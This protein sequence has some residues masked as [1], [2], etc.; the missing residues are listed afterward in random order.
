MCGVHFEYLRQEPLSAKRNYRAV[1]SGLEAASGE[2][3]GCQQA[4]RDVLAA[5]GKFLLARPVAPLSL[6]SHPAGADSGA[7][8][9]SILIYM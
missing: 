7:R 9:L 8:R 5:S 1:S 2:T 4:W 6:R 3:R